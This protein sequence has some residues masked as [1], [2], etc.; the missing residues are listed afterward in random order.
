[1]STATIE[2]GDTLE[3]EIYLRTQIKPSGVFPC[4]RIIPEGER[5]ITW[6]NSDVIRHSGVSL[7]EVRNVHMWSN[8]RTQ[9]LYDGYEGVYD[10]LSLE[11]EDINWDLAVST[12]VTD[13]P[14]TTI[15]FPHLDSHNYYHWLIDTVP[16]VGVLELAGID[17]QSAN[18]IYIHR[19]K[20]GFQ[21][22]MLELL[23]IEKEKIMHHSDGSNHYLFERLLIPYFRLDGGGWPHP[24]AAGYLNERF[25]NSDPSNQAEKPRNVP[26]K[27]YV[28]RGNARRAVTN[29]AALIE[30]LTSLGFEIL[31]P[32]EV[33][34]SEQAQALSKAD[35]VL[36]SHGAGLANV[37]FC[38]PGTK[39]M[40]FGGHYITMHFRMLS[41]YS[42]LNY[43]A[44]AAGLDDSGQRLPISN[45]GPGRILDF[46]ADIE[47]IVAKSE[48]FCVES[49][50]A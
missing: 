48:A 3:P 40:E 36:A 8:M 9:C 10:S 30:R 6:H 35:F 29:E 23:G 4:S 15:L 43:R 5:L 26:V 47:E 41:E 22:K 2:S 28:A 1:M 44:I 7:V 39:I 19:M 32:H 13:V 50:T 33:S 20:N 42:K 11:H 14:G 27:L 46:I 49:M 34:F 17:P 37:V 38:K 24:W 45:A 18:N 21:W 16:C 12:P 25:Q 31:H